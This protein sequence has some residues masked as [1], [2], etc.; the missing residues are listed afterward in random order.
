MNVSRICEFLIEKTKTY[1]WFKG[2]YIF[3]EQWKIVKLSKTYQ[4][5]CKIILLVINDSAAKVQQ[6]DREFVL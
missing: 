1:G 5:S 3:T 6:A 4:K 2:C